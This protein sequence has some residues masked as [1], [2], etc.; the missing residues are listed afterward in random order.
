MPELLETYV[1]HVT[2]LCNL[3]CVYCYEPDK[4]STYTVDEIYNH[5]DDIFMEI[6]KNSTQV[7]VEFLGGE[8]LLELGLIKLAYERIEQKC[9]KNIRKYIISSNGTIMNDDI[10]KFLLDTKD[11]LKLAISLD[12]KKFSNQLRYFKSSYENSYDTVVKNIKKL[13]A[14]NYNPGVHMVTHPYNVSFLAENVMHIHED[15]C[16]DEIGVGIVE[17]TIHIDKAF[18]DEFKRQMEKLA[19]Y[20]VSEN[21]PVHV[22]MFN[23]LKPYSDNRTYVMEK[24]TTKVVFESYGRINNPIFNDTTKYDIVSDV[25]K[26]DTYNM[27]YDLRKHSYDYYNSLLK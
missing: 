1:I 13:Q 10:L 18:C 9:G 5:I 12:G 2:K 8:P 14:N 7:S 27:I 25:N 24:G 23:I 16:I 4:T 15:L 3:D 11:R 21:I 26:S 6:K 20:I 19:D 17:S 22:D